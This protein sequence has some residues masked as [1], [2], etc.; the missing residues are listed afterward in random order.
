VF[1]SGGGKSGPGGV[2]P[3]D[4]SQE[5]RW[6][7]KPPVASG[8][9][10]GIWKGLKEVR[11]QKAE[12]RRRHG[13]QAWAVEPSDALCAVEIGK[14]CSEKQPVPDGS[15]LV[16]SCRTDTYKHHPEKALNISQLRPDQNVFYNRPG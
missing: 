11:R 4:R 14:E 2:K 13:K 5:R 3:E 1:G 7:S 6:Y 16:A 12:A 10:K 8:R 15:C 9:L